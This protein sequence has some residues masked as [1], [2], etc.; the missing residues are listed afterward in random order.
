MRKGYQKV[1]FKITLQ[2]INFIVFCLFFQTL[3]TLAEEKSVAEEILEVLK[4]N[5]QITDQQYDT[6]LEKAKAE[7]LEASDFKTY[8]KEGI[9]FESQ[10]EQFKIKLGGQIMTDFATIDADDELDEAF[11]DLGGNGFE[12]RRA[13]L[14]V[15]GDI[16]E[17]V[18]FK[19][20]FD[21]AGGN[22]DFKDVWLGLKEIPYL[23]HIRLGHLKEPFSLEEQTSS[24]YITFMERGLPNAFSP[25]R[26]TGLR[27]HNS[28]LDDRIWWGAGVF[29]DVDDTGDAFTD[30]SDYNVTFRLTGLPWYAAKNKLLHLGFAYSHQFRSE[31]DNPVRYRSRPESHITDERLVDTGSIPADGVDLINPELAFIYGPFS[32]QGEYMHSFLSID[33][34]DSP[35]FGAF[36]VYASYILTGESRN[37]KPSDGA[38]S[39][40]KPFNNF[41]FSK[42]GWG[43]WEVA[44]RFSR[45]DLT[46]GELLGG[47]ENN[48]TFGLNWYLNPNVRWM[49]NYIRADVEDNEEVAEDESANIFQTRFQVDF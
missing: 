28:H 19:A 12:F 27:L 36:Y 14:Y 40:L 29:K 2:L 1:S 13:R 47:E 35:D 21:F 44:F 3:D 24:K 17:N 33:E 4:A 22:V 23:G 11:P 41:R 18:Q 16:Y 39:R 5:G 32:L 15:E 43:A 9:R 30:F 38:F 42:P 6:L 25:A 48:Y 49:F 45:M 7:K 20:Q 46:D 37:Y 26:N 10:D 34:D 31:E 8:W